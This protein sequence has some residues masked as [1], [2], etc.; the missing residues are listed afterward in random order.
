MAAEFKLSGVPSFTQVDNKYAPYVSCFPTSVAMAMTYCLKLIKKDKTAVGCS[1]D[2][3]LED[4]INMILDDPETLKW[5]NQNSVKLGS[6]IAGYFKSHQ[7]RQVFAVEEYVFNRLMIPLG[8]KAVTNTG[9]K[10][11]EYCN[12]IEQIKLPIILSGDFSSVSR[13]GGHMNTGIGFNKIGLKEVIVNDPYGNALQ[14]YPVKQ[15]PLEMK[16]EAVRYP[17]KFFIKDKNWNM[18]GLMLYK[19]EE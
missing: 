7:Q 15:N 2:I 8:F 14:G 12:H 4:Y 13:I 18:W 17:I 6:W 1:P 11:E 16:A 3:S 19:S 5:Y 9:L 10:Y